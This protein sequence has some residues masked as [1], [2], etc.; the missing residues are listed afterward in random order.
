MSYPVLTI[1]CSIDPFFYCPCVNTRL[2]SHLHKQIKTCLICKINATTGLVYG[3]VQSF[4]QFFHFVH[5]S[6][7][8]HN[9]LIKSRPSWRQWASFGLMQALW[10]GLGLCGLRSAEKNHLFWCAFLSYASHM[11]VLSAFLREE[12]TYT[13][14]CC[15]S[16]LYLLYLLSDYN[17]DRGTGSLFCFD[18]MTDLVSALDSLFPSLHW[19]LYYWFIIKSHHS[20]AL[21]CLIHSCLSFNHCHTAPVFCSIIWLGLVI[22]LT[23]QPKAL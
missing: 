21:L 3:L 5:D 15:V 4:L 13:G 6:C 12:W 23:D 18:N 16:F 9:G 8:T 7:Q 17:E 11:H 10:F 1:S 2:K 20:P 14:A 22:S 19:G